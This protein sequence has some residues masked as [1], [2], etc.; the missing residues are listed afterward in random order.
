MNVSSDV[1]A[2]WVR[3]GQQAIRPIKRVVIS[4]FCRQKTRSRMSVS[5]HYAAGTSPTESTVS[6]PR[7]PKL[8]MMS[9]VPLYNFLKVRGVTAAQRFRALRMAL[10]TS[11]FCRSGV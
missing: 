7:E 9:A 5:D 11:D 2:G 8:I 4:V 1:F 6:V 10:S 3:V